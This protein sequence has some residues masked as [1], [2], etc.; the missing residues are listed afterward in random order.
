[1]ITAILNDQTSIK[2]SLNDLGGDLDHHK[3]NSRLDRSKAA[4]F[5]IDNLPT[6]VQQ[7]KCKQEHLFVD[8]INDQQTLT[9]D[10][11]YHRCLFWGE[12]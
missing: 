12:N 7:S 4:E 11:V 8:I 10:D 2:I 5:G 6:V 1:M 9:G 3:H